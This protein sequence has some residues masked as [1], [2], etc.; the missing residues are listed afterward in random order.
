[1]ISFRATATQVVRMVVELHLLVVVIVLAVVW[2]VKGAYFQ[3]SR[4]TCLIAA[5]GW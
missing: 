5:I 1:M 2:G 4:I 3:S